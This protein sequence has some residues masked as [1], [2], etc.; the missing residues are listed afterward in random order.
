ME[1]FLFEDGTVEAHGYVPPS[2]CSASPTMPDG[3]RRAPP[4]PLASEGL[5]VFRDCPHIIKTAVPAALKI[6]TLLAVLMLS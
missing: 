3:I 5:R 4:K 6:R 2:A 1:R